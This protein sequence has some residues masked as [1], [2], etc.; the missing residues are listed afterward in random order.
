MKR[1][2]LFRIPIVSGICLFAWLCAAAIA[3]AADKTATVHDRFEVTLESAANY[4]NP[5]Q[6][7]SITATFTAPDGQ[8]LTVPGFWDG[9]KT[10]RVRFLPTQA[11]G[12]KYE[13]VCSDKSNNG[14]H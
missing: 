10:W 1:A 7:T 4:E 5:P 6:E 9:G 2:Q 8:K 3:G 13:I 11:G 14:L 12:W